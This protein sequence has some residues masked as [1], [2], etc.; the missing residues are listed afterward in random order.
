MKKLATL[1]VV[2]VL[3]AVA[4][5]M[6]LAGQALA[7]P[8]YTA[9]VDQGIV[10]SAPSGSAYYP[11]VTYDANGFGMGS[12]VY[13]MWYSNGSGAVFVVT[14]NDGVNWGMPTSNSGLGGDAHHVQVLYD[15]NCFGITPCGL[16]DVKYKVWY[17]DINANLYSINAIAYAESSDGINW[18][19]DQPITQDA[20]MKLVTGV[21]P[22]WNRGSYGPIDVIYQPGAS[23]AGTDPWNYNYVMYYD[24]TNGGNE[25]TGLAYSANGL[26]WTAYSTVSVLN[27]SLTVAWDCSDA[28]YGTIY[29]DATG[30]HFWYSGGGADDGSGGCVDQPVHQGI[31]YASSS[32]GKN[33]TK[34]P[35]N[36]IFHITDGV[37]YR[38]SRVYTPAVVDDSSGILKMYYSARESGGPKKIGLAV[39]PLVIEVDLDI[40]P[41]SDPNSIN[42]NSKGVVPVAVLT[43]DT[44]DANSVDPD[45]VEFAG[46]QPLRWVIEDVDGDGDV[47]LLFHFKTQELNLTGDST[48]ATLTGSTYAGQ[49][50]QGT[51]TVNIVPK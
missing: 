31:G 41:G 9:W 40:K 1:A 15:P 49:A 42:P 48:E 32:D 50:I 21:W 4:G 27:G 47:D 37:S 7:Q 11:S 44:F 24:G 19:N 26:F 33:W 38:N 29:Q 5:I 51:D 30:Y 3:A 45:T 17:W 13:K 43:M 14:S 36:P 10:Y 6:A 20:T 46:A 22:N 35:G 2:V 16:S 39:L 23:N 8:D 18:S 28:V 12:P 34:D 25:F